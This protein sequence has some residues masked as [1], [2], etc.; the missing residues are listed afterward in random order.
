MNRQDRTRDRLAIVLS[1][2]LVLA[3]SSAPAVAAETTL[4]PTGDAAFAAYELVPLLDD[5]QPYAGPA[6][7]TSL[8]DVSLTEQAERLLSPAARTR[9]AEQ[10]FVVVPEEVRLFHQAYD[11]QYYTGTPVYVTTDA[12]Y[13]AW[14]QVFDKTLRALETRRLSPALAKLLE[15]RLGE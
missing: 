12:A 8:D 15:L 9:L 3:F 11:E 4:P 13:H 14:H 5:S 10:G 6:T 7:P 2:L 1:G